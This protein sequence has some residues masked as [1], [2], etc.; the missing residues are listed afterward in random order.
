VSSLGNKSH[1]DETRRNLLLSLSGLGIAAPFISGKRDWTKEPITLRYTSHTP[2]SHG[3]YT[4][5]FVPF[6]EL[7]E[8]ETGGRLRLEPYTDRILHGPIDGF[9]AATTGITDYTHSYITYQPGSFRLLHAPQLPFLFS[10]PQVASLVVEELYPKHFKREFEKMGVYLAHCDCTSPYNII[11]KTPIRTLEDLNGIKIRATGGL[12]SEIFRELGA[13]PVA[14][15][16]AETYPAFQRGVIDA[17]SLSASD[18]VAYRLQEIGPYYTRVDVNVLLLHYSLNRQTFDALPQDLKA[19]FYHLLR[20]RSQL[21]AQNFYSG[22]GYE[23]AFKTLRES[24]VEVFELEEEELN[25]WQNKV[26]PLKEQFIALHEAAGLPARAVVNDLESL[27]T[28]YSSLT[29]EQ[30]NEHIMNSPTQGIIDL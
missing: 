18:I 6:A 5:G 17:V 7:V 8:R 2:R 21:T 4:E 1:I 11:S 24:G 19:A 22:A 25:R 13:A 15:A 30:I 20:I 14:I 9:K 10:S 12:T 27:A 3:L 28:E 16:A 29:N 26:A 23:H